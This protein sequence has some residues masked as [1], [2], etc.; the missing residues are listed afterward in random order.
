MNCA[1]CFFSLFF[2][3]LSKVLSPLNLG[4]K[5]GCILIIFFQEFFINFFEIIFIY[6]AKQ[7]NEIFYTF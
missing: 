4:S 5:D 2:N 7:I 1:S 3:T 6:P